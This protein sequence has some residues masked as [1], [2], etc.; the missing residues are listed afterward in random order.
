MQPLPN[1]SCHTRASLQEE[2]QSPTAREGS[3]DQ[4][5][6]VGGI[7]GERRAVREEDF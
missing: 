2:P 5:E 1:R 3:S 7:P 4:V 6:G